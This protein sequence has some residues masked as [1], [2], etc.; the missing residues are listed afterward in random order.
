MTLNESLSY[1]GTFLEQSGATLTLAN[2]LTLT[3]S[4]TF[5][6]ATVNGLGTL[7]T[8]GPTSVTGT[9]TFASGVSLSGAGLVSIDSN[10]TLNALGTVN[11][12]TTIDFAGTNG[13]L[14]IGTGLQ[15]AG[16]IEGF[17]SGDILAVSTHNNEG[18]S[19]H[20]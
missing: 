11:S 16:T 2:A 12:G 8:N 14:N 10:S 19:R 4:A 20:L 15:F 18:Y 7:T 13:L 5:A 3:G 1:S 6:D 17:A 9:V